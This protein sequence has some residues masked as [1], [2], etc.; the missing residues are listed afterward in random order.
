MPPRSSTAN[1]GDI[2]DHA[3]IGDCRSAALVTKAG[4]VD[5]LCWPGFDSPSVFAALL[6]PTRGGAFRIAPCDS[7]RATRSYVGE[8]AVLRTD[9]T[10]QGADFSLVDAMPVVSSA[11]ERELLRPE[12]ELVRILTCTRGAG[13]VDLWFEPRPD[14]GRHHARLRDDGKLGLRI[15]SPRG[16]FT[17]RTDAPM[18][19]SG[20]IGR[21][22]VSLAAGE[23]L[24]FSFTYAEDTPA[25]LAPLGEWTRA[26]IERTLGVWK[27]WSA[28]T[29]YEG[30][31]RSAVVRSAITVRLLT[32]APSGAVV[33]APTTSLPEALGGAHNWDYRYCWLR[34]A[35]FTVRSMVELGH[36]E[37][38]AAFT[39]W[40][41]HATRLTQP[42]LMVLYD[43]FGRPPPK[44][45]ELLH[46]DGYAGSRPVRTGNAADA[47]IQLDSY[48]EVID[49]VWRLTRAGEPLDHET[50]GVIEA[51]GRYVCAHWMEPDAGIW[52][53]RTAP[54]HHT[55]SLA[56]CW[57]ALDRL[58]DLQQ[59]GDMRDRHRG[60][61]AR[62]RDRIRSVI[63]ERGFDGAVG[64][65]VSELDGRELD[66]SALLLGWYGFADPGSVRMRGT[67]TRLVERLSPRPGL[68]ERYRSHGSG[69]GAF[70]ICSF[71]LAEHLARGG[72][73]LEE[74]RAM[75]EHT[76][77][78]ANDVGLFAEEINPETGQALGNFPQTFSHVGLLNAA[79]SI[80]ERARTESAREAEAAE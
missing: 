61:F 52:E 35:A 43:V 57:T 54:R 31:Y 4:S 7:F 23:S 6:D 32:F 41:I 68:L 27:T 33:A 42:K 15:E 36:R 50:C 62:E 11:D 30:P 65:Y 18:T 26:T 64:S 67:F 19:C 77:A 45:R 76:L 40:L 74:A 13:A 59:S 78:Y 16:L 80:A 39:R 29:R 28:R 34:D 14:Y 49:A 70:G 55:H 56:L 22:R 69:E 58:V 5:W 8:T 38:A 3:L 63:E 60:A 48:G 51:F 75:F 2:G 37:E 66:A 71:W 47:Q 44:E 10:T 12:H 46:L 53:P 25:I 17:L 21:G 1:S 20:G 24:H 72:G 9:F 73:S 79:L